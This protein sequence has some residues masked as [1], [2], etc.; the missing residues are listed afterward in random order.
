MGL[1]FYI[2]AKGRK[3]LHF[4]NAEQLDNFIKSRKAFPKDAKIVMMIDSNY[5][6]TISIKRYIEIENETK[7]QN[8]R[9]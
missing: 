5:G 6:G 3:D 8:N 7:K 4:D 2:T 9:T 1:H